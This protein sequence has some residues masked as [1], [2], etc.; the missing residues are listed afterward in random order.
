MRVATEQQR[1]SADCAALC[2]ELAGVAVSDIEC[3]VTPWRIRLRG[4]VTSWH[5][6]QL[7]SEAA[8]RLFPGRR[9]ENQ[10]TVVVSR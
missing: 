5:G 6:K 10:L 7:A 3:D 1:T 4:T 9:I 8:R 2:H